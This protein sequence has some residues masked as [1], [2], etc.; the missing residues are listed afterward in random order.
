VEF[1]SQFNEHWASYP[2][3][4]KHYAV[5]YKTGAAMPDELVAKIKKSAK[6]DQ[7]YLVTE[8]LTAAQLDMQWHTL[9]ASAPLENV[10]E[11]EKAAL[12]RTHLNLGAVP[13]RYRSSYFLHIWAN[14]YAAGYYA[15]SWTQ[16]LDDAA[17]Q[18]FEDHGGLTRANGDRF[19]TM[20]L[21]RGNTE[22]LDR[23]Y[24]TWLG[25]QPTVGPMLKDLGLVDEGK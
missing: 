24:S 19:R 9:P 10:D 20:V 23:M 3:V 17:Y 25:A 6:F 12:I 2:S 15:Y 16:M 22:D 18:R 13:P 7:G 1:P 11:F 21:S 5:H 4:F 8:A 14:G